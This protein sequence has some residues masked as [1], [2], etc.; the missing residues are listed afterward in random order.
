[1]VCL[2]LRRG[3]FDRILKY[4]DVTSLETI[5]IL[6]HHVV[7]LKHHFENLGYRL[8]SYEEAKTINKEPACCIIL[9]HAETIVKLPKHWTCKKVLIISE[10]EYVRPRNWD[11]SLW[12]HADLVL[13]WK[14][15]IEFRNY[16]VLNLPN[17][18]LAYLPTSLWSS[19]DRRLS[20]SILAKKPS[21]HAGY[22]IRAQLINS[23]E[24]NKIDF[25]LFGFGWDKFAPNSK[26]ALWLYRKAP[27]INRLG[28]RPPSSYRGTT[29]EKIATLEQYDFSF[30]IENELMES[31]LTEKLFHCFLSSTV[32]IYLGAANI[33]KLVPNQL[34]IDGRE[35]ISERDVNI[36]LLSKRINEARNNIN[37]LRSNI[38]DY[39]TSNEASVFSNE[40]WATKIVDSVV[41]LTRS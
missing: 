26:L 10:N 37:T 6:H 8:I 13:S 32:P 34:F 41:A 16:E 40:K 30:V 5:D 25:D 31:F 18:S 21:K 14:R 20:C 27:G 33:E 39:I 19:D 9:D 29:S 23:I 3:E 24:K 11:Q 7:Y 1:M 4:T 12:D 38:R 28:P 15:D 36:E 22:R 2:V 35:F 17:F